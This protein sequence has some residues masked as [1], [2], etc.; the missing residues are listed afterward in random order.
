[1]DHG[2]AMFDDAQHA[3]NSAW[4]RASR[5]RFVRLVVASVHTYV[6]ANCSQLAAGVALFTMLSMLPLLTLMVSA[7]QPAL[8][9]LI[10]HYDIRIGVE[11]F[12]QV[13]FSP[14]ARSWMHSVMQSLSRNSLVVDGFSFLAF[15][16]AAIGAFSQLDTAFNQIWRSN[17][18]MGAAFNVRHL[19]I[20]QVRQ[21]RN[22]VLLLLLA[23]ASFISAH[24]IGAEE[25]TVQRQLPSGMSPLFAQ[26]A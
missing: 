21:R 17:T 22:A 10:P 5:Y 26:F 4:A 1:M 14:V 24:F 20:N 11:R 7:L 3:I 9:V 2:K 8:G 25:G 16:W 12:V 13:A 23:L 15:S 19:F 6:S 18:G